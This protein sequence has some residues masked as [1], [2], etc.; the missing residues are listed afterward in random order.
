MFITNE[1]IFNIGPLQTQTSLDWS[2][3]HKIC[4]GVEKGLAYLYEESRLNILH[5][6]IKAT[7][8]LLNQD[9]NPKISDASVAKLDPEDESHISTNATET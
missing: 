1:I 3:R 2:T 4:V 6:D 9:L 5:R 7:Y 8:I